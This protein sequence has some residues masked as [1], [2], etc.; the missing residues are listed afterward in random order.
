M[1]MIFVYSGAC[2]IKSSPC[3]PNALPVAHLPLIY[4]NSYSMRFLAA[5][6]ALCGLAAAM[7]PSN[8]KRSPLHVGKRDL[9]DDGLS[10]HQGYAV[11]REVLEKRAATLPGRQHY[12]KKPGKTILPQNTNTTC[13]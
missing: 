5:A 12:Y 10:R 1:S 11:P 9:H 3:P 2:I 7:M 6:T 4:P 13:K 8:K